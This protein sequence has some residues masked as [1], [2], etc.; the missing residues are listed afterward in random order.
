M[1]L[2]RPTPFLAAQGFGDLLDNTFRMMGRTW[3]TSLLLT[4]ALVLP[5]SALL[6][7]FSAHGLVGFLPRFAAPETAA[8]ELL[9]PYL[10]FLAGLL[11]CVLLLS[12][13]CLLAQVAVGAHVAAEVEGRRPPRPLALTAL[14]GRRWFVPTLLQGLVQ[15]ALLA[16]VW[17]LGLLLISL[18]PL[19]LLAA[20][21]RF[22]LP[23][24]LGGLGGLLLTAAA[25]LWLSVLLRFAPQAVVFDGEGV[26]GSLK[27]S[28]R[29]VRGSWWR[30]L[31]ICLVVSL[32][33]SFAAGL[34]AL[35]VGGA[36][37]LPLLS[38]LVEMMISG[39]FD[40]S[41]LGD[42]FAGHS[43]GIAVWIAGSTFI[44]F[45]MEV[46][47]T[48]VFFGL[49]YVDLRVRGGALAAARRLRAQRR[50]RARWGVR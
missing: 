33:L 15:A 13:A 42:V 8:S 11:G 41:A 12:L 30:L 6:G 19:L 47:F 44:Q 45:A 39:S 18:P 7:W 9:P 23:A 43:G 3:R 4:L 17:T 36:A 38:R 32:I 5:L 10:L 37:L 50:A 22:L 24:I 2:Q 14:A 49:F 28:A 27:R 16:G 20:G 1:D 48:P 25:A 29:V 40:F 31:G 34:L 26:F 35:P 21:P 46:F